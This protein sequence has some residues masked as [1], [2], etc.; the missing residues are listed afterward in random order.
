M[1]RVVAEEQRKRTLSWYNV[2]R[3]VANY[4]DCTWER[5]SVAKFRLKDI[6]EQEELL[7]WDSLARQR[8]RPRTKIGVN[9]TRPGKAKCGC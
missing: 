9:A 5:I 3:I 7:E 4:D 2:T 1:W 8:E 6:I